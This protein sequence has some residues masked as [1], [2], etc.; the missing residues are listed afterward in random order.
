M[1]HRAT[2]PAEKKPNFSVGQKG[3]AGEFRLEISALLQKACSIRNL[4][5]RA[6]FFPS[7]GNRSRKARWFK[8]KRIR[9]KPKNFGQKF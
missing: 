3:K 2:R 1:D 7:A 5:W 6:D 4:Q 8:L 9:L